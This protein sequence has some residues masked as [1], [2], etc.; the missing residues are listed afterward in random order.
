MTPEELRALEALFEEQGYNDFRWLRP[1]QIVVAQW[2]RMQCTYGCP[3][4]GKC[5]VCPPHVPGLEECA[6][7][8][9][10]YE[11]AAVLRFEKTLENPEDRH[12]WTRKV[13]QALLGLERAVF[14]MGYRKAFLL[15]MDTCGLCAE[16]AASKEECKNPALSRPAP[17]A[18]AVD[19]FATARNLGYPI[20]VLKSY[21]EKMN[22]YAFLLID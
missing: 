11:I 21:K 5:S 20:E 16:C 8:F 2:V 7:F 1:D 9:R 12:A 13:N 4:Y 15:F 22:R 14:L 17:E 3:G 10:E 6:R 19:V 18:M